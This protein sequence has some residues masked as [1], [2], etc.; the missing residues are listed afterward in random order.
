MEEKVLQL[1]NQ[2]ISEDSAADIWR[3]THNIKTRERDRGIV[4]IFVP[5]SV[6][7]HFSC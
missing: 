6:I 4:L 2:A 5:I 1:K 7:I 3:Y